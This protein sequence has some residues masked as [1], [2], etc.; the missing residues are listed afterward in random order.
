MSTGER[1]PLALAVQAAQAIMQSWNMRAPSCT[2]VGS[3][4]RRR[5]DVGDLELLAPLP[6]DPA[7]DELCRTIRETLEANP[8]FAGDERPPLTGRIVSGLKPGFK[9]ASLVVE[10]THKISGRVYEIPVQ[11]FRYEPGE[12]GNR[13]W[14]ELMRTGPGDFG[15]FFLAKWKK[16][17]GIP[18]VLPASKDGHLVDLHGIRVPCETE[19]DC[20]RKCGMG[21]IPPEAR[22]MFMERVRAMGE[23]IE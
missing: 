9:E 20:F 18:K 23:R 10:L 11:V 21:R 1:L 8:L 19:E 2:I 15:K 5:P 17:F 7:K 16:H 14:I 6:L 3:V 4:R 12:R 13:G 22:D